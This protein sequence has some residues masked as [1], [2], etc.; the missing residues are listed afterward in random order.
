MKKVERFTE[1]VYEQLTTKDWDGVY[2]IVADEGF[3]KSNL[4]LHITEKW[5]KLL[6]K[7]SKE[8]IKHVNLDLKE[9]LQD[10]KE[11][12]R[13]EMTVYDEAGDLAGRRSMSDVNFAVMKTYQVIRGLNLLSILVLP[14]L[15]DLDSFF[16]KRRLRGMFYVYERGKVAFWNRKKLREM[17]S[18]NANKPVRDYF[19]VRP[20]W[21]DVFP[22]YEG[23]LA[24][25]YQE[26]KEKKMQGIRQE[27]Y[28]ELIAKKDHKE[29]P[30]KLRNELIASIN[31]TYGFSACL[32]LTGLKEGTVKQIISRMK[33][34]SFDKKISDFDG[35]K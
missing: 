10:L 32:K 28:K 22:K 29:D 31:N 6:N 33:D 12:K 21:T 11:L 20:T 13:Y 1:I 8:N 24:K 17:V 18:I 2:V 34:L 16:V 30:Y 19:V 3:G 14:S 26:K 4:G 5:Y 23:I 15:W 9:W 7:H 35:N 27:I 25:A